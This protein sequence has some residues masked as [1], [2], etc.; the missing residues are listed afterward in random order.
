M[1]SAPPGT[2][3]EQVLPGDVPLR[4][5]LY[6]PHTRAPRVL[7]ICVHG[8]SRNAYEYVA[9]LWPLAEHWGLAL[10]APLFDDPPFH[11][12]QRLGWDASTVR[13]DLALTQIVKAAARLVDVPSDDIL[14]FGYSG[15]AQ[16]VHRYTMAYPERVRACATT[17]A[18]WYTLPDP[19]V[20]YPYGLQLPTGSVGSHFDP[21]R[22]LGVPML[23]LV[24]EYDTSR[25]VSLR[26]SPRLDQEQGHTR[27]ERAMRFVD[28][29][30]TSACALALEPTIKLV[31]LSGANHSFRRCVERHGL[32]EVVFGFF[33]DVLENL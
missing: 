16:F 12:Y 17:S 1:D 14:L 4:Y 19:T 32:G 7:V 15:G 30:R 26:T 25:G 9:T 2:I 31:I 11:G 33:G 29:M 5:Y 24:G 8:I 20:V 27:V 28:A 13:A 6:V 23:V 18:G 10:V 3:A 21:Q 22:F